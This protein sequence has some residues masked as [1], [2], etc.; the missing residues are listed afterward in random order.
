M[1]IGG[2]YRNCSFAVPYYTRQALGLSSGGWEFNC[3]GTGSGGSGNHPIVNGGGKCECY[4]NGSKQ[5]DTDCKGDNGSYKTGKYV[6]FNYNTGNYY[7]ECSSG[8]FCWA[9]PFLGKVPAPGRRVKTDIKGGTEYLYAQDEGVCPDGYQAVITVTPTVFELGKVSFVNSNKKPSDASVAYNPGWQN[10]TN[11]NIAD[12]TGIMQQATKLGLVVE[13]ITS[14]NQIDGWRIAMGT[15]T[16]VSTD[17]NSDGYIWNAGGIPANSW[18]AI[19]H[20]YCYF[21]PA[22]FD[23]PNMHFMK[24][25]NDGSSFLSRGKYSILTPQDNPM[26]ENAAQD[27]FMN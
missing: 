17:I 3:G 24:L 9:H 12:V 25:R 14:E 4:I 23:M 16:P 8:S 11:A 2:Q 19:A 6:V 7:T 22:R 13:A 1:T 26:L 18:S 21:N 20:T 27:N 10:Y 15:V 5:S